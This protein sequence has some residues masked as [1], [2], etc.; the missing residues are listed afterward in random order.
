MLKKKIL[1]ALAI[2]A[3]IL[4][5]N[6]SKKKPKSES[7]TDKYQR[8][9]EK[10]AHGLQRTL[11]KDMPLKDSL[12]MHTH[13]SYNSSVY[14]TAFSYIDPN[15]KISINDQLRI[16]IRAIELDIHWYF[17]MEGWPWEWGNAVLLCHGGQGSSP[18]LG[19]SSYD[20]KFSKGIS[21][22]NSFIRA[23]PEEVIILYLEDHLDGRHQDALNTIKASFGDL[24]YRPTGNC[25]NAPVD[26]TRAAVRAARKNII[27]WSGGCGTGEW[28]SWVYNKNNGTNEENT[29]QF[30]PYPDCGSAKM[31]A[32][33]YADGITRFYEDKT[34]LSAWFGGG[35]GSTTATN[36]PEMLKCGVNMV[37][38][39][40]LTPTD[41]RMVAGVYSWDTNQPDD[42]AGNEDCAVQRSSGRWNDVN[43]GTSYKFACKHTTTDAWAISTSSGAFNSGSAACTGLGTYTFSV[44]RNSEQNYKLVEAKAAA[45]VAEVY[46]NYADRV[47]E[48]AWQ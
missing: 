20:R 13:N 30:K 24:I 18:H 10:K 44:P 33:H 43:C 31:T 17:S 22:V 27:V 14:T 38:M 28:Q 42:Y 2:A 36:I 3:A 21:E 47:T 40:K 4:A 26:L 37:G 39:D 35:S 25:Q 34:N 15:Q 41:G 46:M 8:S 11:E 5:L 6:A 19:C 48:G 12:W 16:D 29:S 7:D 45:G 9:W 23:N 32:S 1:F